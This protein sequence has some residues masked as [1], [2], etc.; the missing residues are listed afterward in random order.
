[1][2]P[3]VRSRFEPV[4]PLGGD[5]P[6]SPTPVADGISQ[7]VADAMPQPVADAIP[8]PVEP[9]PESEVAQVES[10]IEPVRPVKHEP[11]PVR[12]HPVENS[13]A[14]P[15][16][17]PV[18]S[19]PTPAR[20]APGPFES[21]P[22]HPVV[23]DPADSA[24]ASRAPSHSS[25]LIS[26]SHER[27]Y[28]PE[29]LKVPRGEALAATAVAEVSLAHPAETPRPETPAPPPIVLPE[30]VREPS[31]DPPQ[32]THAVA[33]L[34]PPAPPKKI[35]A[36][37]DAEPVVHITIGRIEVKAAAEPAPAPRRGPQRRQPLGL[38][39]YLRRRSAGGDRP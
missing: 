24:P 11:A 2:R 25:A 7:P 12:G 23:R 22:V 6:L 34:V 29:R 10:E 39:E 38:D 18:P 30:S 9:L 37:P 14:P 16:P 3:L 8:Q 15:V 32:R 26:T 35:A 13:D 19:P 20:H 27:G 33:P 17:E 5:E 28:P 36:A 4:T 1:V 31:P 21:P